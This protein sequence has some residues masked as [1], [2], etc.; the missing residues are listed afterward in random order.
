MLDVFWKISTLVTAVSFGY[1]LYNVYVAKEA[2]DK[3]DVNVRHTLF[4]THSSPGFSFFK[5]FNSPDFFGLAYLASI[6]LLKMGAVSEAK[7][8]A[9]V[10][11]KYYKDTPYSLT[12]AAQVYSAIGDQESAKEF[13]SAAKVIAK[14][15]ETMRPVEYL[16][17]ENT[18]KV[19]E[20]GARIENTTSV[21]EEY[22][23]MR[24]LDKLVI[25]TYEV[26]MASA[27]VTFLSLTLSVL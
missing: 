1:F 24:L 7:K 8:Y 16:S 5:F 23:K 11:V 3:E 21:A 18:A 6:S 4:L 27:G 25:H 15:Y 13:L 22:K 10:G 2:I 19:L 26:M 9:D 12:T 17:L 20:A 14:N